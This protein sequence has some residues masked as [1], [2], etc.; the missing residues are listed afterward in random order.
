MIH[1]TPEVLQIVKGVAVDE[2]SFSTEYNDFDLNIAIVSSVDEAISHINRYTTHHSEAIVTDNI[3]T[4]QQFMNLIDCSTVYHNASTRFTD[5]FEFG[6]GAEIGIS[7]Q[8]LHARGPMGLQAL[9]SYKYFVFGT[10][11]IRS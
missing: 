2:N 9:T 4:A 7:T 3:N 8:K 1:G 10:G 5:G 11:Q 6:F